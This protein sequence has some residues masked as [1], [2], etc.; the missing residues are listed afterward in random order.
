MDM[1][2]LLLILQELDPNVFSMSSSHI[3]NEFAGSP[4][5]QNFKSA[6]FSLRVSVGYS[7][8]TP[9]ETNVILVQGFSV[10][11]CSSSLLDVSGL[12]DHSRLKL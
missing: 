11:Y 8:H 5:F 1:I 4:K 10:G 12:V 3:S 9:P 2:V 7:N 6:F